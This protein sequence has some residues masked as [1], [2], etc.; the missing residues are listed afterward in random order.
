[1]RIGLFGYV[2]PDNGKGIYVRGKGWQVCL[3]LQPSLLFRRDKLESS[4]ATGGR[5]SLIGWV[6]SPYIGV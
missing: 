6:F 2:K 3:N 1:M 4:V 5:F